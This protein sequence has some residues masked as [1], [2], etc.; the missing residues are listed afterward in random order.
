MCGITGYIGPKK[1]SEII[2]A[3]LK[4]VEYRG[5]DSAGIAVSNSKIEIMKDAGKIADIEKKLD[6]SKLEG[7]MGI[8]HTRWATHGTVNTQNA[9]PHTDCTGKIVLVHNGIIENFAELKEE[10]EEKGHKFSSETDTEMMAHLLEEEERKQPDFMR[11][12]LAAVKR[13]EGS[14]SFVAMRQGDGRIYAA[15]KSCPLVMGVGKGEMFFASDIPAVLPYTRD[16]VFLEEGEAASISASDY[17]LYEVKGGKEKEKRK[18]THVDW[19]PQMAQKEGHAH[20]M[21]KEIFEQQS[22]IRQSLAADVGEGVKLLKKAK[23]ITTVACGTSYYAGLL[24]KEMLR[25][26]GRRSDC[27][28][29]SEYLSGIYE[30]DTIVVAVSQSGE[31]A[32]TLNAVR[33]AKEHGASVL[34][35]TNVVGSSLSREADACIYIGAG[36]EIAVVATKSFTSQLVVLYKLA[37]TLAKK[38]DMVERMKDLSAIAEIVLSKNEEIRALAEKLAAKKDFFFI[39][40]GLSFPVALEGALKLKE[41]TYLHAEAYAAGELKHGPLSLLE[42]GIPII[43]IAPS[44]AST[45]KLVSNIKECKARNASVFAVSDSDAVLREAELKFVMPQVDAVFAPI[46]YVIPL[47]L[48]AYHMAVKLGKDPDKPRNLAKSVTVE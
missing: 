38:K 26:A 47:Q 22:T 43:A 23:F 17:A 25:Q 12:F 18:P 8:G 46:I 29:G 21:I 44:D 14:Y 31:T 9:H 37:L 32:D 34:G 28:L 45:P 41:I 4:R 27:V 20:F 5:Y 15:R 1:A 16:F 30:R 2:L 6:F 40:R 13:V 35:I 42:S 7:N 36:P 39:G 11:A 33:Y 48:L 10:L 19:T 3:S 24:F